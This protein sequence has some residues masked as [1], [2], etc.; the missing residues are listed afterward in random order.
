MPVLHLTG[1][2]HIDVQRAIDLHRGWIFDSVFMDGGVFVP[3][4]LPENAVPRNA[5]THRY[6]DQWTPQYAG[7]ESLR[8]VEENGTYVVAGEGTLLDENEPLVNG[9]VVRVKH[10]TVSQEIREGEHV[11]KTLRTKVLESS[12]DLKEKDRKAKILEG[13][14]AVLAAVQMMAGYHEKV[15]A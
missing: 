3:I 1:N 12:R 14:E 7:V 4:R 9:V 11:V 10:D 5:A 6:V 15:F 13:H 2:F 8:V